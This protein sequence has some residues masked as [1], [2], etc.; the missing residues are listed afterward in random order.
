MYNFDL[1][2]QCRDSFLLGSWLAA[3]ILMPSSAWAECLTTD[4]SEFCMV[5]DAS[6]SCAALS[7]NMSGCETDGNGLCEIPAPIP[8]PMN[9]PNIKVQVTPDSAVGNVPPN[10]GGIDW[11]VVEGPQ[12]LLGKEIDIAIVLGATGGG[13]SAWVYSPG[14]SS[15][16]GLAFEKNNGTYQKVNGIFFCS[17]FVAPPPSMPKLVLKKTVMLKGGVC[18][19]DDVENLSLKVDMEVE[20][21]FLVENIG[22]GDA[23]NVELSD[24][25]IYGTTPQPG[26]KGGTDLLDAG[27]FEIITSPVVKIDTQGETVNEASVTYSSAD[28]TPGEPAIDTATVNAQLALELCPDDYQEAVNKLVNADVEDGF[29]YAVLLDPL[30]PDRLAICVPDGG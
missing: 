13:T 28:S 3:A 17:D 22:I 10:P 20:Y 7:S 2:K 12:F 25:D 9:Y 15:D 14:A 29:K 6:S 30:N 1:K 19:T 23:F 26:G 8:N 27:D 24:S 5:V 21:C 18:G 16:E 4:G 11:E